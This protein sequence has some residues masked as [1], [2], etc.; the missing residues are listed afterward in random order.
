M[1]L[2]DKVAVVVGG[3]S[4]M[5]AAICQ[6][7]AEEGAAVAVCDIHNDNAKRLA[8]SIDPNGR[9]V[10]AFALDASDEQDVQH[11]FDAVVAQF[12]GLD[13]VVNS[14]GIFSAYRAE[15]LPLSAWN[16]MMEVCLT[17]VFLSCREA[18][19]HMIP[20]RAGKI[21]NIASTAGWSGVPNSAHYTAAKHGVVG[22][23][24]ALA[25]DWGRYNIH[26]NCIC[27]GATATPMY[28]SAMSE[29][30]QQER[31]RRVPMGRPAKPE[32]Q[33]EVALFLAS[34]ESNYLTG[35]IVTMDGGIC[36]MSPATGSG[37]LRDE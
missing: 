1:R 3:A 16:E 17:G 33:A 22:L 21:V 34:P 11:T 20:Q 29:E 28:L 6:R 7:F 37:V 9:R 19:R 32:E 4:G 30:M 2:K 14:M 25:L 26:V 10:C 8:Q 13:I 23:T 24:K 36:A 12:G 15:I 27:P 5:G 18:A 31:S 35:S